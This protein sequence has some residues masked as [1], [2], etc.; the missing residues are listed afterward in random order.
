MQ[1]IIIN[2]YIIFE[3][4]KNLIL[5]WNEHVFVKTNWIYR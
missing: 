5:T 4:P 2:Y 1:F 3:Q